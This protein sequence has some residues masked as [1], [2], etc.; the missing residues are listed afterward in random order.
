M[1]DERQI[2]LLFEINTW[3]HVIPFAREFPKQAGRQHDVVRLFDRPLGG[4]HV[5]GG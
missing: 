5:Y 4:R 2:A 1:Q 3:H